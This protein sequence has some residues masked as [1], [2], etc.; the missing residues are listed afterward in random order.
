[1]R[2]QYANTGFLRHSEAL[3]RLVLGM[4]GNL[5]RPVPV[6]EMKKR[7]GSKLSVESAV[8][9]TEAV[10]RLTA[11]LLTG[12]LSLYVVRKSRDLGADSEAVKLSNKI[13]RR[14][15]TSRGSFGDH[16]IRP[17]L[18]MVDNDTKMLA[19]LTYGVF[20]VREGEFVAWYKAER[21]KGKWPSQHS[22]LRGGG[23]PKQSHQFRNA[24]MARVNEGG[25]SARQ[26][27]PKLRRL[28]ASAGYEDVP[29]VDTLARL[30]KEL[31]RETGEPNLFKPSRRTNRQS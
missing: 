31:H 2:E 30:V 9:R 20:V 3:N 5:P 19:L 16:A 7:Y 21:R 12:E 8:W 18:K 4:W 6:R 1:M 15:P 25:W 10:R 28:L 22:K 14:L 13:L 23:R 11:A 27:V 26:G 24:I 17:S 29:S